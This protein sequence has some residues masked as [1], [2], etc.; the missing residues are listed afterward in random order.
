MSNSESE[1]D[2]RK[3]VSHFHILLSDEASTS[4][5]MVATER[6]WALPYV[7]VDGGL[8]IGET[9]DIIAAI[10][11][12]LKLSVNFTILRYAHLSVDEKEKWDQTV[13]VLEVHEALDKPPLDGRW[14]TKSELATAELAVP[15]HRALLVEHLQEVTDDRVPPKRTPWAI[16]GWHREAVTWIEDGL[17]ELGYEQTGPVEQIKNWSIANILRVPTARGNVYFKAGA[18]LPL[19]VN[20]PVL[21]DALATRFPERIPQPIKID[22]ERR[23]M[24]MDDFGSS[25]EE[26]SL[27]TV[28]EVM[29]LFAQLQIASAELVDELLAL[30]L[31][32]RRLEVLHEQIDELIAHPLTRSKVAPDVFSQMRDFA[33]KLKA[34]W[35]ELATYN[36]PATLGHGD[37]HLGNVARRGD[38]YLFFDWTDACIMHPFVD[39]LVP[40]NLRK[41]EVAIG[42]LRDAYLAPWTSY[43]SLEKLQEAWRLARPLHALHQAVSYLHI[44]DNQ[45][46]LVH[47]E[48][49]DGLSGFSDA[50]VKEMR[51]IAE[52]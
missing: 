39:V 50:L 38:S 26:V 41:D 20:E 3:W 43:A 35:R 36:L 18:E 19:F 1:A 40:W 29:R 14:I 12:N 33:P 31:F 48:L 8:W 52:R 44:L 45:E 27:E 7:R 10:R 47:Q 11:G 15:E 22:P 23:W 16:A 28:E 49:E 37:M 2:E 9:D 17:V 24:L 42:R 21:M 34:I 4:V 6:G 46:P 32:D 13:W 30:G 51:D 25:L 5:L